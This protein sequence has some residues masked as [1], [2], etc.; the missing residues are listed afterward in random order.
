MWKITIKPRQP[1][2]KVAPFWVEYASSDEER[3]TILA[4]AATRGDSAR[5]EE[6]SALPAP[7]SAKAAPRAT[8]TY[9]WASCFDEAGV[10]GAKSHP[11]NF[12]KPGI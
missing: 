5:T 7:R 10:P 9:E 8:R 11:R 4:A 3:D 12:V 2:N 1:F 6:I